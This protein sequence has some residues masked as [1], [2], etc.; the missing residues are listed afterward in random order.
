MKN[1]CSVVRDLLPLYIEN[2]VSEDTVSFIKGHLEGCK[3]CR[4]AYQ[5]LKEPV[6]SPK[7]IQPGN[8]IAPLIKLKRRITAKRIKTALLTLVFVITVLISFFAIFSAPEFFPYSDNLLKMVENTD[9]SITITFDDTVTNYKY[10]HYVDQ[11]DQVDRYSVEAW[12][13]PWDYSFSDRGTQSFTIQ[14]NQD[15]ATVIYYLQNN[16]MEDILIYGCEPDTTLSHTITL[17]RLVLGYY[18]IIISA[19]FCILLVALIVFRKN[20]HIRI[21]I[22]RIVLFPISYFVGHFVVMGYSTISYSASR[23]FILILAISALVYCGLLLIH[24]ICHL[25]K[26]VEE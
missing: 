21:W 22:E 13:C 17:P 19:V 3:E 12:T 6:E 15:A 20:A 16:G 11:N 1:E 23:D 10:E 4:A 5:R 26:K 18:L 8:D 7:V 14:P 9:G 25:N 2:I 24:S